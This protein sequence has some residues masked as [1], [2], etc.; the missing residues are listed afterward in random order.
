M[1]TPAGD[2]KGERGPLH[3][4]NILVTDLLLLLTA[5]IWGFAF[6]AQRAGMEH[7]GPF[8]FNGI[9]FALGTAVLLPMIFIGKSRGRYRRPGF[10]LRAGMAAGLV[11]F[12]ERHALRQHDYRAGQ[13]GE[14]IRLQR[15]RRNAS[16]PDEKWQ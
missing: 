2:K 16:R 3:R 14:E 7:V 1:S 5:A 9:R 10:P 12:A 8:L 13:T 6:V 15:L 11:I 4:K